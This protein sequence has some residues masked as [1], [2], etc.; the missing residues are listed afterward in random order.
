MSD[1]AA[2]MTVSIVPSLCNAYEI[3]VK[4]QQ[5]IRR[6]FGNVAEFRA[7]PGLNGIPLLAP[8]AN[9][10]DQQ[11]FFANGRKYNFDM[12]LGNVRGVIPI[13]GFLSDARD[14][15]LKEA[16]ADARAAWAT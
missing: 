6:T 2:E 9:R 4:G 3:S 1:A 5:V 7:R 13:H 10:L 16:K 8:F 12:E 15:S 14:W 11:A